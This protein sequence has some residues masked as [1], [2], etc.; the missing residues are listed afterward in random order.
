MSY[1]NEHRPW[2]LYEKVFYQLLGQCRQLDFGKRRF[3][4]RN[5]LFSLDATVIEL[6]ASLFDWAMFRQTKGVVKLHLLLDHDGY[7]QVFAHMTDGK[8]HDVKVA[9]AMSFPP[10]SIVGIDKGYVD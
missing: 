7:M 2:Q 3:R 1:A 8:V 5:K 10:G 4:F 6:C 9:Q